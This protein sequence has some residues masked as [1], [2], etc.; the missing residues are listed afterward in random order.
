[1]IITIIHMKVL[2]EKRMELSQAIASLSS[3]IKMEMGCRR[4]DLYQSFEDENQL[5]LIEEWDIRKN[6]TAYMESEHFKVLRG[7]MSLL[8]E[9]YDMDILHRFIP[10]KDV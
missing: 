8:I 7:A 2:P 9:P 6:L 3:S 1:M 10:S 5:F 4:C